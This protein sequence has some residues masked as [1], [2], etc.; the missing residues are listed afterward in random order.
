M[1]V[2]IGNA[3]QRTLESNISMVVAL[4]LPAILW[5]GQD[6]L[7]LKGRICDL[8]LNRCMNEKDLPYDE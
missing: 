8:E 2:A 6:N 1:L 3:Y 7:T 4:T 5:C